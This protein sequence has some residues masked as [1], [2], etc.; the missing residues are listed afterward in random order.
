MTE[1]PKGIGDFIAR[2]MNRAAAESKKSHLHLDEFVRTLNAEAKLALDAGTCAACISNA[3]FEF[4]A[5]QFIAL[6]IGLDPKAAAIKIPV[7]AEG[8]AQMIFSKMIDR[9]ADDRA[10]KKAGAK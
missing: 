6:S 8:L 9:M 3:A 2:E 4:A 10:A 7:A 5:E 1:R